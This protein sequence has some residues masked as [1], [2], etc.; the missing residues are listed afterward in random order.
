[1]TAAPAGEVANATVATTSASSN[2]TADESERQGITYER[3]PFRLDVD[4]EYQDWILIGMTAVVLFF[5]CLP[6]LCGRMRNPCS[7]KFTS[8]VYTRL[9][10]FF[11]IVSYLNLVI[12]MF[13]VGVLPDWSVNQY[14]EYVAMG[15]SWILEHM[16]KMIRCAAI[17]AAFFLLFK[18]RERILVAAGLEHVTVFRFNWRDLCG[19]AFAGRRRPI[20]VFIWKVEDVNSSAGK[21]FKPN[22]LFVECH[23]GYNEPMRTRVHNNAGSSCVI[24]E[25][26][27]VNMDESA[28]S[29]LMT[30]LVMDQ[31][32]IHSSE[33]ARLSL[34]TREVCGIE[35][36]TGKRVKSYEDFEY[37][38]KYFAKL[39]M[40][41]RGE[42]W[43]AIAPVSQDDEEAPLTSN[44]DSLVT[45]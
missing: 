9:H 34:S 13:V 5:W 17:L 22:D 4:V 43:L 44:E 3:W 16:V 36:K 19:G 15:I 12:I 30:V 38:D 18:F 11:C 31:A 7:R 8:W 2:A 29:E 25:S 39:S 32:L 14:V 21:V 6:C 20:E 42:I 28:S 1:M 41:P 40:M 26:F 33:L 27:Q 37:S 23:L 10:T 24:K 35:D 45:C